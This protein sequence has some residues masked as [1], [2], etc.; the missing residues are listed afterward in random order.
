MGHWHQYFIGQGLVVNG[1]LKGYDEYAMTSNFRPEVPT[2][3]DGLAVAREPDESP[4]RSASRTWVKVDLDDQFNLYTWEIEFRP[5]GRKLCRS[6]AES[7][8]HEPSYKERRVPSFY[9]W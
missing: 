8:K 9:Y 4:C 6:A 2:R 5:T 7:F 1:S 3:D